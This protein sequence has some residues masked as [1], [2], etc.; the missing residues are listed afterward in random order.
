[1]HESLFFFF[2]YTLRSESPVLEQRMHM[3]QSL[4]DTQRGP[5][6][7]MNSLD[8]AALGLM[9]LQRT[10]FIPAALLDQRVGGRPVVTSELSDH[11]FQLSRH[12]F[13]KASA[14]DTLVE[15]RVSSALHISSVNLSF[16]LVLTN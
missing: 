2:I 10:W 7:T 15:Y 5:V 4:T 6:K 12:K 16:P 8:V 9:V 3:A 11:Y 1:M 14:S 13:P